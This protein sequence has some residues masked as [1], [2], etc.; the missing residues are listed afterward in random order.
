MCRNVKPVGLITVLVLLTF[1][2]CTEVANHVRVVGGEYSVNT[3]TL[4]PDNSLAIANQAA[5]LDTVLGISLK[6]DIETYKDENAETEY[7]W[8]NKIVG[9]DG[10]EDKIEALLLANKSIRLDSLL[11]RHFNKNTPVV[12]ED[13]VKHMDTYSFYRDIMTPKPQE[14]SSIADF[15]NKYNEGYSISYISLKDDM[16]FWFKDIA[17]KINYNHLKQLY[18]GIQFSGGRRVWL[19]KAPPKTTSTEEQ[20][21]SIIG[22]QPF[23]NENDSSIVV[24]KNL[25]ENGTGCKLTISEFNA[26]IKNI[27]CEANKNMV[28]RNHAAPLG[29]SLYTHQATREFE[30]GTPRLVTVETSIWTFATR[31]DAYS[32]LPIF[33]GEVNHCEKEGYYQWFPYDKYLFVFYVDKAYELDEASSVKSEY[34]NRLF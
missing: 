19:K 7:F 33:Y 15:V 26:L 23:N 29:G 31:T 4:L 14:F 20:I 5:P 2:S 25:T 17:P 8:E 30:R 24:C 34:R 6:L 11:D 16:F 1:A 32:V 10:A 12:W 21:Q 18:I 28:Y 3:Y 9:K 13:D 27:S 22:K